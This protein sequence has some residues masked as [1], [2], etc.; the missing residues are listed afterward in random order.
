MNG[1]PRDDGVSQAAS[2]LGRAVQRHRIYPTSSPLCRESVAECLS[3]LE[4]LPS[5]ALELRVAPRE[6]FDG[7]NPLPSTAVLTE[8]AERLFRADVESLRVGRQTPPKELARFCRQLATWDRR[9]ER[10]GSF[11]EALGEQGVGSIIVRAADKLE[12][13]EIG[14]VSAERLARLTEERRARAP[15]DRGGESDGSLQAWIQVDT[16]CD[17]ESIDLV[18]LAFLVENQADLAQVLYDISEGGAQS[19][20]GAEALRGSIAELIALYS[21]LS[22]RVAE[23]RFDDLARTLRTL[24]PETR[25]ALTRDVLIP[26][27]LET[28]K[29]ARLLRMLPN[30]EVVEAIRTLGEL[31]IGAPGL[32]KL[33]FDRLDLT[34]ERRTSLAKAV[35]ESLG[36]GDSEAES[37]SSSRIRL[38]ADGTEGRDL[39]EYTAL[40]LSVDVETAAELERIRTAL[41]ATKGPDAT[42]LCCANLVRH[43]R[44]PDHVEEIVAKAKEALVDLIRSDPG[45]AAGAV[46]EL[47]LAAESVREYRPEV[48]E[49]ADRLILSV[50]T[51]PSLGAQTEDWLDPETTDPGG[52]DLLITLATAWLEV[53][54]R[55]L[56]EEPSRAARRRLMDFMCENGTALAPVSLPYLSDERWTVVRNMVRI[57]G[58]A[59]P[60]HEA[61]LAP[62]LEH[63]QDRVARETLLALARMG[64]AEAAELVVARLADEDPTR[65]AMAEES[66]RTFPV[67]EGRRQ[68]RRLL[69]DRSFLRRSPELA[70]SLVERF[71]ASVDAGW[72]DVLSPIRS[73]RFRFWNRR[74]M[75]LGRAAAAA[76]K[77]RRR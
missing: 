37:G 52:R 66:I 73:L 44:N 55:F 4:Q 17:V 67:E 57:I 48:S 30:E 27:L 34:D 32:V 2:L 71:V 25:N 39:R 36:A 26:D 56:E 18:D 28:G 1:D 11:A 7:E 53:F 77:G 16:D 35:G 31:E 20:S 10:D 72:E 75:A 69:A 15:E 58:F 21:S 46:K 68:T 49:A 9:R 43:V 50:F 64:T 76:L 23:K 65:R 45:Q 8:L 13:L 5:E 47:S 60:G 14:V 61:Q 41:C 62:L 51:P 33:A 38:S 70:R 19:A 12:V 29:A 40:E 22:P 6:L 54:V 59:G 63:P 74:R 3:A 24:D 42:L